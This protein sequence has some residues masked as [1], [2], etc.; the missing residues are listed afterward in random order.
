MLLDDRDAVLFANEAFYQAFAERDTGA[1]EEMWAKDT[2]VLCCHPG[3]PPVEGRDAVLESWRG[4]LTNPQAPDIR[5]HDAVARV[6]GDMAFVLCFEEIE[7][8]FL[9]ATNVFV[10]EGGAWRL[11]HHTAAPTNGKPRQRPPERPPP[12][13]RLN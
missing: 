9:I 7:G 4:I 13:R 12:S 5:C 8:R 2:P 10:R 6:K 11:V 1:M 3:W